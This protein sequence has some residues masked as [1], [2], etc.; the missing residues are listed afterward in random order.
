MKKGIH[1]EY[2]DATVTCACG[3]SFSTRSTRPVLKI[4]HCSRFQ[5]FFRGGEGRSVDTA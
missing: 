5:L 1:P 4:E 3:N 2:M